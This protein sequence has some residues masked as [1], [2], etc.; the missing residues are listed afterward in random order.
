MPLD[1]RQKCLKNARPASGISLYEY[2]TSS[3]KL[4]QCKD[5]SSF[6]SVQN[7]RVAS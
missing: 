3:N 1:G 5:V 6:F 2:P 4:R 7:G